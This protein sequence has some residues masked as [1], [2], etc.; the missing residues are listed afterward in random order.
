M[1]TSI[2]EHQEE[3]R[4]EELRTNPPQ[5]M[6]AREVAI[7]LGVSERK[8]RSETAIGQIRHVRLG[9]RILYRIEDIKRLLE[10]HTIGGKGI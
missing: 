2:T 5:V 4:S 9:R 10:E 1:E 3:I 6:N 8:V 7:F